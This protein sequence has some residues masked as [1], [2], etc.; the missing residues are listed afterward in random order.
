[1]SVSFRYFHANGTVPKREG[2]GPLRSLHEHAPGFRLIPVKL[3]SY[4]SIGYAV[5]SGGS[6]N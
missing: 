6:S 1:M 4:S 3:L 2:G 5:Y